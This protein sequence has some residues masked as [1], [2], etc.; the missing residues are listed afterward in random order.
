MNYNYVYFLSQKANTVIR[1]IEDNYML[2]CKEVIYD[3]GFFL[4]AEIFI[5]V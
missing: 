5:F 3:S 1:Y 4:Y 2:R